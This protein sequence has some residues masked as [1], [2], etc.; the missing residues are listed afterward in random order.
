MPGDPVQ[1]GGDVLEQQHQKTQTPKMFRVV[2]LNDDYTTME[3]VVGVLESVFQKSPAE[4]YRLMMQV[5]TQG[6]AVCG[7]YTYEVAETKAGSVHDLASNKGVP[8]Q[9]SIEEE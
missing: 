9:A 8:L 7:I 2:L 6:R 3:F 4:A 5:H 1:P